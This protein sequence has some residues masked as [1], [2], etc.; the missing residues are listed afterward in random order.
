MVCAMFVTANI[1]I[2]EFKELKNQFPDGTYPWWF[3]KTPKGW[4]EIGWIDWSD[5]DIRKSVTTDDTMVH[6]WTELKAAEYLT[7][8][9]KD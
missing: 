2:L 9:W 5:T 8:L 4:I 3:V 7:T 6:A 1:P